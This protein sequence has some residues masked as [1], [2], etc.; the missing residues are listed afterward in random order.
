MNT[1]NIYTYIE[2]RNTKNSR[3]KNVIYTFIDSEEKH[4]FNIFEKLAYR[5]K[6]T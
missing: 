5:I 6:C 3:H 1:D 4:L 2:D